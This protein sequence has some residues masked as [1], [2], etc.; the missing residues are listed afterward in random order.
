[1]NMGILIS[2]FLSAAAISACGGS[3]PPPPSPAPPT[4][5]FDAANLDNAVR[6]QDDFYK[7]VNGGWLAKTQIPAEKSSYSSFDELF[8]LTENQVKT[9]I[10]TS[11]K[12]ANRQSG[13]V[14]QVGDL[15]ASFMDEAKAESLGWTPIK[16]HL[17]ASPP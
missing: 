5:G 13:G 7:Y 17:F 15:Y 4:S 8:D 16:G 12:D 11:A 1:M 9:I 2:V 3:T 6:P 10:E 14:Q